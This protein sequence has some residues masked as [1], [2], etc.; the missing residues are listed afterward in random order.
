MKTITKTLITIS[1]MSLL[2]AGCGDAKKADKTAEKPTTIEEIQKVNGKPARVV[3]AG[4]VKLTDVRA[5][6][7]TIE[8]SQQTKATAKLSDPISKVNVRVG[9]KVKKDQVLAEFVFTGDNTGYQEAKAGIEMQEK[10][11]T[12]LKEVQAKGGV[13]Q[14]DVDKLETEINVAKMKMETARRATLV[15]APSSGTITEV[16]FKVGEVPGVGGAMFT[17]ANLDK[18][19]LKLNVTSSEIGF[20]KKGA[21]A[22]IEL[23]GEKL[24][25]EVSLIPLAADPATRFFPVEVTFKNKGQKLLPGMYLTTKIDAREVTGVTVPV[26]AIVYSNGVNSVWI[27]DNEGKA[28]RKIV[29]L[30]VQTKTDIQIKDGLSEGDVVMVEGQ[31]RMNDGDKV[32][33]VE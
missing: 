5:F 3:K 10:T 32:L 13:S 15:L 17:I 20:F 23:N 7:G 1:A 28:K 9:S 16:K 31:N 30:G 33:I 11:L 8:G 27:V 12:R 25:G 24:Q 14:Q 26:E 19:I 18:V 4:V 21:K 6:S 29:Q 22:T 2:L